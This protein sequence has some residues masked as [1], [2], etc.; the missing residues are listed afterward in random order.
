[1]SFE[2]VENIKNSDSNV[3]FDQGFS[4][5]FDSDTKHGSYMNVNMTAHG[6]SY[7]A[8]K[9]SCISDEI[10]GNVYLYPTGEISLGLIVEDFVQ[11]VHIWNAKLDSEASIT[12]I[13]ITSPEGLS[14]SSFTIPVVIP[15]IYEK[16]FNITVTEDGPPVQESS[17]IYTIGSDTF[18][19]KF[20]GRRVEAFN[21]VPDWKKKPQISYLF[22]TKIFRSTSMKEQR[23]ALYEIPLRNIKAL[24]TE[25]EIDLEL[26]YNELR[27]LWKKIVG[28]PIWTERITTDTALQGLTNIPTLE[29]PSEYINLSISDLILVR[30]MEDYS[31]QEIKEISQLNSDSIDVNLACNFDFQP[32][33]TEIY[34][35]MIGIITTKSFSDIGSSID[36]VDM[37]FREII[38]DGG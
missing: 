16:K 36:E 18:T 26:F 24:F 5:L 29:N 23:K 15:R 14:H 17:V 19:I 30:D 31:K 21:F 28:I 9:V 8:K 32:Q 13:Q 33:T 2:Y 12:Q 11:E 34:P 22:E 6:L 27:R 10:F 25:K 20:S 1:M 38:V 3:D 7:T 4:S 35:V 37:E